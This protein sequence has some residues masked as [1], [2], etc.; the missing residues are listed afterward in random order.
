MGA[1]RARLGVTWRARAQHLA[2]TPDERSTTT[3]APARCP[4]SN[5]LLG[6]PRSATASK[7]ASRPAHRQNLSPRL[8][9]GQ[10]G[11]SAARTPPPADWPV[12]GLELVSVQTCPGLQTRDGCA[13]CIYL[14]K[15]TDAPAVV[16]I[17]QAAPLISQRGARQTRAALDQGHGIQRT[18]RP[19]TAGGSQVPGS[20]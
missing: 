7:W 20:S 19:L 13:G 10:R 14:L 1:S 18:S 9:G 5:P 4:F 8:K 12:C 11:V 16:D 15:E 6:P 17:R 3:G 2:K